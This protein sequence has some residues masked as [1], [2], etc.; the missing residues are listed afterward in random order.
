MQTPKA[1]QPR[2]VIVGAGFGG[3]YAAKRLAGAAPEIT[4]IDRSNHHLF[5]PLLYQVATA[6]LSAADIA[7]PIRAVFARHR[8]VRVIMGEV[9]GV[10]PAARTVSVQDIGDFPYDILVLATGSGTSWFGHPEWTAASTGLKTLDDAEEIRRRLLGAFEWAESRTDP[11]ETARLMTFVV[12]GGGPTGVE[13]AGSI[14][15][16]ARSTLA[17]DFRH[18][19]SADARVVLCDAGS[20]VLASFPE[21]L[22]RYA[23]RRLQGL[24]VELHLNATV[25]RID[26]GGIAA[27]GKRIESATVLWA[28]GV[29]ATSATTWLGVTPGPH[30]TMPVEADLSVAAYPEIF[31]I[32]DVMTRAGPDGKPL[33]GLATVA[34]QQGRY[35]GRLIARRLA[36]R[37]PPSP[38]RYRNWGS[39]AIIGR[40]A[41]VGDFGWL[42]LR[43][44]PAWMTWGGVHL[45]LLMGMRNRAVVYVTWIWSW[46]TW[47]RGARLIVG[48]PAAP[49]S[50]PQPTGSEPLEPISSG[51]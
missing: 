21:A 10:D 11:A 35:V 3:L 25:E 20:R 36:G 39:L 42:R 27:G 43:G 28:A 7:T 18:I 30:G 1:T 17:R 46:L 32:G 13:L 24:G 6:A 2:V 34:K 4:L 9:T 45:L 33:P 41:A 16:L 5:Q 29:A 8:N 31:A 23:A 26:A 19:R 49:S 37:P 38:F 14:A 47:G 15:E 22:S 44:L 51:R 12:V 40:S 50:S 48:S